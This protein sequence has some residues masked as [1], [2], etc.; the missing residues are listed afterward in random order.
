MP[1]RW[2]TCQ[3]VSPGRA[4]DHFSVESEEQLVCHR[5]ISLSAPGHLGSQPLIQEELHGRDKGIGRGLSKSADRRV[6]H[7]LGELVQKLLV[8]LPPF[9][10]RHR[11]VA[12]D[13][14]RRALTARLVFEEAQQI[15][16]D[17]GDVVALGEDD[18]GMAADERAI[19]VETCRNRAADR[20]GSPAECRRRRRPADRP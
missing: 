20:R 6:A 3:M 19:F 5:L 2:A 16:H 13:P 9:E 1:S 18:D 14:A 17:V 10:Q 4:D 12:A 15:D 8:P 7:G 11:L